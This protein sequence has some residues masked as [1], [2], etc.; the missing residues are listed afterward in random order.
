MVWRHAQ[1]AKQ[2]GYEYYLSV[3]ALALELLAKG[4]TDIGFR[5]DAGGGIPPQW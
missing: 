2:D 4:V 5:A 1:I 3:K